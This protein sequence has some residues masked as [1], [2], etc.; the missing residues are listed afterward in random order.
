[1]EGHTA[2]KYIEHNIF[3]SSWYLVCLVP[4]QGGAIAAYFKR[5]GNSAGGAVS[6]I[7]ADTVAV[8]L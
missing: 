6:A 3:L 5:V 8:L 1:M 7:V 4:M 2:Q